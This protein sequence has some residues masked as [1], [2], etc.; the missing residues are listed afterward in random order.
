MAVT[1]SQQVLEYVKT[2]NYTLHEIATHTGIKKPSVNVYLWKF[3]KEGKVV[4]S[5]ERGSYRFSAGSGKA[6][7]DQS[8]SDY[9]AWSQGAGGH[10]GGTE[11][12]GEAGAGEG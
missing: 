2:G 5:G 4:R 6:E 3:R 8:K 9:D 12:A 10:A 11:S 7:G 1:K